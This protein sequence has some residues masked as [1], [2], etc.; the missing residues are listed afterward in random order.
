MKKDLI[1]YIS[2]PFCA[3]QCRLCKSRV[4]PEEI[5]GRYLYPDAL[6][7]ELDSYRD[8]LE[9]YIVRGV[10]LGGGTAGGLFDE[11]I[12]HLLHTLRGEVEFAP[13]C[14][15]TLKVQPNMFNAYTVTQMG[16]CGINR[17][18][19]DYVSCSATENEAF[20]KAWVEEAMRYFGQVLANT[21]ATLSMDIIAGLPRQTEHSLAQTLR[22]ALKGSPAQISLYAFTGAGA[23]DPEI[24]LAQ[25]AGILTAGGYEETQPGR[26]ALP[27][28]ACRWFAL[29]RT[30]ECLGLGLG[31]ESR[32]DGLLSVNTDDLPLYLKYADDPEKIVRRLERLS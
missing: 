1:V 10:W 26:F 25:A 14:E 21:G 30:A 2:Y 15:L 11:S 13:D 18:S 32:M 7:K 31:S 22:Q 24:R 9:D 29:E 5:N 23:A 8:A 27:G 28:K 16:R 3:G 20:G 17:V 19:L 12:P 4:F 6:L